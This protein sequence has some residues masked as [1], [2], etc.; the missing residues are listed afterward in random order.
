MQPEGYEMRGINCSNGFE[1]GQE[2]RKIIKNALTVF[3]KAY[4][5]KPITNV[6]NIAGNVGLSVV[7]I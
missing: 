4:L 6:M 2:C 3:Y 1:L 7:A 5:D